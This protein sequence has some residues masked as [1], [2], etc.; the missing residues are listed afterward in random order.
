V[1]VGARPV[2]RRRGT[3]PSLQWGRQAAR[4]SLEFDEAT[5]KAVLVTE[6]RPPGTGQTPV[7]RL[8]SASPT[9][10]RL[11]KSERHTVHVREE[12]EI[13]WDC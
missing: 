6:L 5:M 13:F 10:I 12:P 4:L 11:A 7:R 2:G 3:A 9:V 1:I 8:P